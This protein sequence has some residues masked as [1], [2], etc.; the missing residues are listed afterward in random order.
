MEKITD[1]LPNF[2]LAGSTKCAS[3]WLWKSF[4]EHPEIYVPEE[5]DRTNFFSM[6]YYKGFEWY[7]AF[8]KNLG[9]EKV[10]GDTTPEYIKDPLAPSRIHIFNPDAK[11]IFVV[12]NP[13]D[14]AFS[15]W[16]HQKRKGHIN[17]EFNDVLERKNVGSFHLYDDWIVSGFYF[18]WI[19]SFRK[20]FGDEQIKVVLYEDL[21]DDAQGFIKEVFR[22]LDVDDSFLPSII[23]TR[24]N[25]GKR[26]M[27]DLSIKDRIK[28]VIK[29]DDGY[30]K[31]M[32]KHIRAELQ[33]IFAQEN[34]R[35]SEYL[36]RDLSF[37]K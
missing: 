1:G 28:K 36:G 29:P 15:L 34:Q 16:W 8:Y 24:V 37:W 2:F 30:Q 14:R 26:S 10:I 6:N 32:D 18:H 12:R 13:I 5:I 31:G 33:K 20:L 25:T 23:N 21:V 3:T 4:I 17:Y 9:E 19:E 7:K 22:F 11:I 27:K 35:L